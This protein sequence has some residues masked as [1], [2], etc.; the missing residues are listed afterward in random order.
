M[1]WSEKVI[2]VPGPT[3]TVAGWKLSDWSVP[4]PCGITIVTEEV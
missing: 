4:T 1:S 3:V 2:V